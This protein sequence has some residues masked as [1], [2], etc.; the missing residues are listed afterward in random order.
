MKVILKAKSS[1]GEPYSV[2]FELEEEKLKV[3]CTCKAGIMRTD[4][5]HRISLL[6]G[7]LNMLAD[8]LQADDLATVVKWSDR[9]GFSTLLQEL[10]TAEAQV[11]FARSELKKVK[12]KF[13]EKMTH[14]LSRES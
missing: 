9:S 1:S 6:K 12:E 8:P 14:G 5:K 10:D 11:S 4:C 2:Q 13:E 3:H 7:D